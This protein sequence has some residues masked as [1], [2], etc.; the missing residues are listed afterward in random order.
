[1]A[2]EVHHFGT[3]FYSAWLQNLIDN[4]CGAVERLMADGATDAAEVNEAM[5]ELRRLMMN[6]VGA[7]T[8]YWDRAMAK[9]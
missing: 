2:P 5:D 7:T 9:R 4:V 3:R 6:P 1:M 8:F